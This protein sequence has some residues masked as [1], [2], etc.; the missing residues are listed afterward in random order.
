MKEIET[1]FKGNSKRT[2]G[3]ELGLY[4]KRTLSRLFPVIPECLVDFFQGFT[5]VNKQQR[6]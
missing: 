4:P 6:N 1:E 3:Q 2:V 5:S